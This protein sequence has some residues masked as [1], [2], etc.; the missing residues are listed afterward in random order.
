VEEETGVFFLFTFVFR[1]LADSDLADS[2]D[3][4]AHFFFGVHF[5]KILIP[6]TDLK[7]FFYFSTPQCFFFACRFKL[8]SYLP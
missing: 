4:P 1:Q 7:F 3:F 8:N 2:A 6:C 5:R